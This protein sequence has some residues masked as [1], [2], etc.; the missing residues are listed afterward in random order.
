VSEVD[1]I[2]TVLFLTHKA[3]ESDDNLMLC[4]IVCCARK[5]IWQPCWICIGGCGKA[6][7]CPNDET[8]PLCPVLRLSGV[9]AVHEGV[10]QVRNR[11]YGM[12]STRS[13]CSLICP[14]QKLRRQ[15]EHIEPVCCAPLPS[16]E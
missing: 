11:I 16:R 12:S 8:N 2:C 1:R 15:K 6:G 14:M 9:S 4:A 5:W 10:L 3:R 13:G 7:E